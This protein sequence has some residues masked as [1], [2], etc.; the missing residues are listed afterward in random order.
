M[1]VTCPSCGAEASLDV[2]ITHDELRSLIAAVLTMSLPLGALVVRYMRLFKPATQVLR[3][4]RMRKLLEPLVADMRRAAITRKGREWAAPTEAWKL[5]IET[6]LDAH[7]AGRLDLPLA[8][9]G[10]LYEVLLRMAD[11]AEAASERATEADRQQRGD[12]A[13]PGRCACAP[14][15]S[16]ARRRCQP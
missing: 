2:L 1:Q 14:G 12:A 13:G 4:E 16:Q 3:V 5:A 15:Q 11:K 10:Y 7:S 8:D 6:V 9:H